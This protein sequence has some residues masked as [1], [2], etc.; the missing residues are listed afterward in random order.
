[1]KRPLAASAKLAWVRFSRAFQNSVI[2]LLRFVLFRK[3]VK[4]IR[5][6]V[7]RTG[8][9]G[10]N[11]C[12]LPAVVAIRRHYL[13]S[14]I[15]LL[16]D[17][18]GQN[19]ASLNN[20]IAPSYYDKVVAYSGLGLKAFFSLV[21]KGRYDLVI[22]LPQNIVTLGL[23]I[24]NMIFFRLAGVRAGLGWHVTTCNSFLQ[25]QEKY[26]S[27][28]SETENLLSILASHDIDVSQSREYPL[29]ITGEDK[30]K[31]D[32]VLGEV[33]AHFRARKIVALVPGAKRSQNRYPF[34]RFM[35][36]AEWL[37]DKG[38]SV[39]VVGGPEDTQRGLEMEKLEGALS[40]CGKLSPAQS[41]VLLSKCVIAI[42]NDTGPMHLS[43][44]VKTPVIG[45]F[46]S[47]DFQQKWFP[48]EGNIALRNNHV[49]CSM[50]FSETCA[51][52]ICMQ[53]ISLER[54]K[55]SF[56]LLESRINA[57]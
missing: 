6:L 32:Q 56:L 33:P 40:F 10:D 48:P 34:D 23:E 43:Y 30:A 14:E 24:R 54:V 12:A 39:A 46:S 18:G 47:R 50:C 28:Q 7:F 44:V 27:F 29:L 15:H 37:I 8:S 52:N 16:T 13:S 25:T 4:P 11:I 22:E 51:N 31:V 57:S 55:E 36:L 2:G 21:K 17:A 45:I 5:I 19:P 3:A 26:L 38:Y 20:L 49:H 9:I 53:G 41:A 35:K 42:S 1:M